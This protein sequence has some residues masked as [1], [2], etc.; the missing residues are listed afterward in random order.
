LVWAFGLLVVWACNSLPVR[1]RLTHLVSQVNTD[2][3]I[4]VTIR[5]KKAA[6]EPEAELGEE[7]VGD[8]LG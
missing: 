6:R 8:P 7:V 4:T 2:I 5:A 3:E 1:D